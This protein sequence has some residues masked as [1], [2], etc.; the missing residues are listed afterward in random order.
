[1]TT[2]ENRKRGVSFICSGR[3]S[4][5]V[6]YN[7]LADP[8]LSDDVLFINQIHRRPVTAI[9]FGR[10]VI[11]DRDGKPNVMLCD[12]PFS[13]SQPHVHR[14]EDVMMHHGKHSAAG[15][16]TRTRGWSAGGKFVSR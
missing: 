14:I 8:D 7:R 10:E 5:S 9:P 16:L 13:R 4:C 15:Q 12:R 2:R 6:S 1:M 3:I 11:V